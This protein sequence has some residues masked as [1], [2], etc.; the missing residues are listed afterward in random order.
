MLLINASSST[1]KHFRG[2]YLRFALPI[3]SVDW[4]RPFAACP[5]SPLFRLTLRPCIT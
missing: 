3:C 2:A 4:L 1:R 5:S